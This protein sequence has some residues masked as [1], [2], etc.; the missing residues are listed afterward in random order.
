MRVVVGSQNPVKVEAT[1]EAF[2]KYF[3]E[4][5]V[6]STKVDSGVQPFPMSQ[7]ETLNGALNRARAAQALES[8]T[9][10]AVGIEG[11]LLEFDDRFYI[12]A[13]AV[14]MQGEEI[15]VGRSVAVEV[16]SKMVSLIDPAS[17]KSKKIVDQLL[18]RSN[19]FQQEGV[20]GVLTQNRLSR[21]QILRDAIICALPRFLL[22]EYY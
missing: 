6:I 15:G 2:L 8:P 1:R 14:V 16:S 11:G 17:D 21:T 22:P 7:E 12:Q 13:F 3:D 5:T 10:F 20:M 18:G 19:L 9:E 4:V